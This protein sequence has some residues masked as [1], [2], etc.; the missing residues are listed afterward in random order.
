MSL[1]TSD[2][3][4]AKKIVKQYDSE[5]DKLWIAAKVQIPDDIL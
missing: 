4:E 5:M 2:R 1:G 3:R